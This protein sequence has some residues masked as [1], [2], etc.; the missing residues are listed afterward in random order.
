MH[1]FYGHVTKCALYMNI[2]GVSASVCIVCVSAHH[3]CKWLHALS[4]FD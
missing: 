1:A 4:L 3:R 2:I